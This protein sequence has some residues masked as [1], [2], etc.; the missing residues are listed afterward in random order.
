MVIGNLVI[1]PSG[2][3]SNL[4]INLLSNLGPVLLVIGVGYLGSQMLSEQP[5]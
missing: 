3:A 2:P 1:A 5:A 4:A